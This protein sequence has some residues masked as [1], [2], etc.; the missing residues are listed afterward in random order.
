MISSGSQKQ[1]MRRRRSLCAMY[2]L[3]P[4]LLLLSIQNTR[5]H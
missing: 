2:T 4:L 5:K 3:L 1:S